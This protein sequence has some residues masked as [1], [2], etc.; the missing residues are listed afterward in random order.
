MELADALSWAS[1]RK[2]GVL[3]TIRKD[4]RPQSSDILY[5]IDDDTFL[6]SVTD[7]RAKTHNMRR[8]PRVVLHITDP[9]IWSYVSFDGTARLSPPAVTADDE[10]CDALVHYYELVAG[11]P[12]PDWAEYRKAMVAEKRLVATLTP[13]SVVGLLH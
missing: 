4:G 12:H 10:T 2:H 7:D 3:I 9:A 13:S 6:I 8:D 5:T 11:K 1:E